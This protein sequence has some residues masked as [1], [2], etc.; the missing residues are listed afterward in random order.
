MEDRGLFGDGL[1]MTETLL[2]CRFPC[3]MSHICAANPHKGMSTHGQDHA[4]YART[5]HGVMKW[6]WCVVQKAKTSSDDAVPS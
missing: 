4:F 1:Q 3:G 5:K 6:G 2:T